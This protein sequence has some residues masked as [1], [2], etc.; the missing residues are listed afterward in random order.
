[1]SVCSEIDRLTSSDLEL[2]VYISK[3]YKNTTKTDFVHFKESCE[4]IVQAE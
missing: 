2:P 1:M 3:V 4:G